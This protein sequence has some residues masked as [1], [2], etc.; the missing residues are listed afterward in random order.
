MVKQLILN[1]MGMFL[2]FSLSGQTLSCSKD[3]SLVIKAVSRSIDI[4]NIVE[5]AGVDSTA[6]MYIQVRKNADSLKIEILYNSLKDYKPQIEK[7]INST[8]KQKYVEAL[9]DNYSGIVPLFLSIETKSGTLRMP[10][11]EQESVARNALNPRIDKSRILP[12]ITIQIYQP[13]QKVAYQ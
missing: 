10:T 3:D 2:V 13:V 12:V 8:F 9:P 11:K 4:D 7:T 5:C 1:L 6:I